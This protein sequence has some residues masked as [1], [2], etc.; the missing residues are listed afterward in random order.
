MGA[1]DLPCGRN[2]MM[3]NP[4]SIV[5]IYLMHEIFY[6]SSLEVIYSKIGKYYERVIMQRNYQIPL[7]HVCSH[8]TIEIIRFHEMT[9]AMDNLSAMKQDLLRIFEQTSIMKHAECKLGP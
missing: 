8:A 6:V 1:T 4:L 2:L 3:V 9:E 5:F 7:A